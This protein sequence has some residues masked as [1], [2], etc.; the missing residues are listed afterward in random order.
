MNTGL[1]G[2]VV[3][4]AI[5]VGIYAY[6]DRKKG[7][8]STLTRVSRIVQADTQSPVQ[9]TFVSPQ[10]TLTP[11]EPIAGQLDRAGKGSVIVLKGTKNDGIED[12][13]RGTQKT[14]LANIIFGLREK[15]GVPADKTEQAALAVWQLSGATWHAFLLEGNQLLLRRGDRWYSMTRASI[16]QEEMATVLSSQR[17]L[18]AFPFDGKNWTPSK[19]Q[20]VTSKTDGLEQPFDDGNLISATFN[21]AADGTILL[22]LNQWDKND[23]DFAFTGTQVEPEEI[24]EQVFAKK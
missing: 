15:T 7:G 3:V 5:L 1:I 10:A 11:T 22:T 13:I 2:L 23:P 18:S 12:Q 14:V 21:T 6:L 4:L 9:T 19:G 8:N 20:M 16:S 24:I 17:T